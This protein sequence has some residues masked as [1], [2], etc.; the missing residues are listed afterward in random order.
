MSTV[1]EIYC[2]ARLPKDPK[3]FWKL[4]VELAY[5][6]PFYSFSKKEESAVIMTAIWM[7][8]DPKS[9]L[10]NSSVPEEKIKEEIAK[11]FLKDKVK[12]F[13]WSDYKNLVEKYKDFC[14]T[15]IEKEL[16]NYL[17]MLQDRQQ[18]GQDLDWAEDFDT[19][20]K[21]FSTQSKYYNEYL[22]IRSRLREEREESLAHGKYTPSMIEARGNIN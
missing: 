5:I 9:S 1:D 6:E 18:T 21:I 7:V 15:K 22:A 12:G 3:D 19:K 14:K 2:F 20:E 11:S 16:D 13:K 8:F 4:N 10:Y 17:L